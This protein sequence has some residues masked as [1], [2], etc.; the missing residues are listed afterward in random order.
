[1]PVQDDVENHGRCDNG[2]ADDIRRRWGVGSEEVV[3]MATAA[4]AAVR[5][6]MTSVDLTD[7]PPYLA[8]PLPALCHRLGPDKSKVKAKAQRAAR[9]GGKKKP[10]IT[11]IADRPHSSGGGGG[12]GSGCSGGGVSM[13]KALVHEESCRTQGGHI[14]LGCAVDEGTEEASSKTEEASS[15]AVAPGSSM[16]PTARWRRRPG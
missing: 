4:R 8:L 9:R 12:G 1:M 2:G 14:S 15:E 7:H 6:Q 3:M 16:L 13:D 10:S 5:Y 11:N